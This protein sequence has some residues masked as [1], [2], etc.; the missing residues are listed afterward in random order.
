MKKVFKYARFV[1]RLLGD[2]I[3][4][5]LGGYTR[6]E[7]YEVKKALK[8]ALK[9]LGDAESIAES[10]KEKRDE[11]CCKLVHIHTSVDISKLPKWI[12]GNSAGEEIVRNKV[13][14]AIIKQIAPYISYYSEDNV[15]SANVTVFGNK[16]G[17]Q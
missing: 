8:Q 10:E 14:A 11:L 1:F 12:V 16:G 3:I 9:D 6:P 7:I 5:L 13:D 15:V 17:T 4:H 2:G